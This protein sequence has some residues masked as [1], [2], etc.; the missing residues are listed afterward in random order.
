MTVVKVQQF[1]VCV[2]DPSVRDSSKAEEVAGIKTVY[3]VKQH[4]FTTIALLS[5]GGVAH[6]VVD[7]LSTQLK[8][9]EPEN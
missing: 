6:K 2:E 5:T 3:F 8:G 7:T 4:A 1:T 9:P